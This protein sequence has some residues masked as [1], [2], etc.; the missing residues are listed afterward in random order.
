[1]SEALFQS[2]THVLGDVRIDFQDIRGLLGVVPE[3]VQAWAL[4]GIIAM[5]VLEVVP[6]FV[7]DRCEASENREHIDVIVMFFTSDQIPHIVPVD[8]RVILNAEQR[9]E[10]R[11][12]I[13]RT[14]ESVDALA[15]ELTI[16]VLDDQRDLRDATVQQDRSFL[17]AALLAKVCAMV[18]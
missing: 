14:D 2:S 18:G 16:R 5:D 13:D 8:V 15:G 9:K 11:H 3:I 10:R 6:E 12:E 4:A 17:D 1:M 7:L